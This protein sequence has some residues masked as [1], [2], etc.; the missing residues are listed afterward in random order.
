[1]NSSLCVFDALAKNI[2]R[3]PWDART[4]NI[5]HYSKCSFNI[6]LVLRIQQNWINKFSHT[7]TLPG[8]L[9]T[10]SDQKHNFVRNK[11]KYWF[12][13]CIWL[14]EMQRGRCQFF[15]FYFIKKEHVH[16]RIPREQDKRHCGVRLELRVCLH[17]HSHIVVVNA[18][19]KSAG[20]TQSIPWT[21]R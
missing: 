5:K 9:W 17:V 18:T 16:T 4:E 3:Y 20:L 6:D 21:R 7:H 2:A 19:N 11:I 13:F 10:S 14:A 15:Y 8:P 1:M 12:V